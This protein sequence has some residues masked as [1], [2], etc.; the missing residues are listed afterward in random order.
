MEV[1]H[2]VVEIVTDDMPFL[3]DSVTMALAT[4][5][6]NI[7]VVIHPQMA[8][9]RDVTGQIQDVCDAESTDV[10]GSGDVLRES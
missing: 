6:R 1:P 4:D 8:V 9:R 10:D 2:T 7:H 3:V 5:H